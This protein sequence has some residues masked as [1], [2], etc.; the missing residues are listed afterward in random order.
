[1]GLKHFILLITLAHAAHIFKR[2]GINERCTVDSECVNPIFAGVG[3]GGFICQSGVCKGGDG[4][5]CDPTI[6]DGCA[7]GLSCQHFVV[8]DLCRA[9][10]A[11]LNGDCIGTEHCEYGLVCEKSKCKA[12]ALRGCS[13]D[14]DCT[15]GLLCNTFLSYC[16]NPSQ[17]THTSSGN[18]GAKGDTQDIQPPIF[19][20]PDL[21][22]LKN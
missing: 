6:T 21:G 16:F 9:T 15:T 22:D 11:Q 19:V 4:S 20:S 3:A 10:R 7:T 14:S 5:G 2:A 1:M 12:N 13:I 8:G 18:P 17:A